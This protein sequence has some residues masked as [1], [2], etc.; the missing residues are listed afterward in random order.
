M[1]QE[2]SAFDMQEY[3]CGEAQPTRASWELM[4]IFHQGPCSVFELCFLRLLTF[5]RQNVKLRLTTSLLLT[6]N[7]A[8]DYR[9]PEWSM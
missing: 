5:L 3:D 2:A 1:A 9:S 7:D 8:P 6:R 4:A